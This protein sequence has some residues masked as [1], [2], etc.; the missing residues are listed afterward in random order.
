MAETAIHTSG[1]SKSFGD[2]PALLEID[3]TVAS[4]EIFGLLGHNGAGQ[5][6]V[7][8]LLTTL[9]AP[10]AGRA[11]V[12]GVDIAVDPNGVR[13][14]IGYLPENVQVYDDLSTMENLRFFGRLSGLSKPDARIHE[15]QFSIYR[16]STNE[17]GFAIQAS[18]PGAKIATATAVKATGTAEKVE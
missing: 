2:R 6:T 13:R 18:A 8:N 16:S 9:L 10:S 7:V 1:L 15:V 11:E 5:T 3:L 4:G 17:V 12:G 14:M